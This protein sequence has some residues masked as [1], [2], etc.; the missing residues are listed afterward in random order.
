LGKKKER[1][2]PK[3]IEDSKLRRVTQGYRSG[4]W[5]T[6]KLNVRAEHLRPGDLLRNGEVIH[7]ARGD[8][9]TVSVRLR[10]YTGPVGHRQFQAGRWLPIE[11][12]VHPQ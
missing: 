6:E 3:G 12:E 9:D 11:R 7:V 1:P 5:S 10:L 8:D 4:R 2:K